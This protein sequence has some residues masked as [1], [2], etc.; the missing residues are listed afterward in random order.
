M[1]KD[2]MTSKE[3][4]S[5]YYRIRDGKRT[6]LQKIIAGAAMLGAGIA[7]GIHAYWHAADPFMLG[8][9]AALALLGMYLAWDAGNELDEQIVQLGRGLFGKAA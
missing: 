7:L 2:G 1:N 8:A 6:V 4:K 5:G 9:S 3:E